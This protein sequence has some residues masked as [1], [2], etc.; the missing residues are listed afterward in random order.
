MV[1]IREA[2]VSDIQQI[3]IV[4]L[5]VKEN[6]LSNPSLVTYSDN[7]EYLTVRGKGWVC[8]IN[9]F[10]VGFCIVDL[11]GHSVWALFVTPEHER[12]GIGKKLQNVMLNWY[13][14]QSTEKL[15][16]ETAAGTRA[17]KFYTSSGWIAVKRE[18]KNPSNAALPPYIDIRFEMTYKDWVKNS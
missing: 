5:A 8:E 9:N 7:K 12:K 3:M 2:T 6:M 17:E 11:T 16:L 10:I 15:W 4:R 18:K 1:N 14:E 13:F